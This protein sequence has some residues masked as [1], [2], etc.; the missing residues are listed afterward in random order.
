MQN[1][2]EKKA[3]VMRPVTQQG[4]RSVWI[5]P[6]TVFHVLRDAHGFTSVI[7]DLESYLHSVSSNTL[8]TRVVFAKGDPYTCLTG[9]K[10]VFVFNISASVKV[11]AVLVV[12]FFNGT[13]SMAPADL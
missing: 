5:L 9:Y 12:F 10:S 13:G 8:L 7:H 6:E 3:V 1:S 2:E 4:F 11:K